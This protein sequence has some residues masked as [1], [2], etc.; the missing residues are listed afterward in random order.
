[1]CIRDSVDILQDI[2]PESMEVLTQRSDVV[3]A[4]HAG[5]P[6]A[7][8]DDP[9]ERGISFNNSE[10]PYDQWQVRWA[11]ALAT[12]IKNVS[13][14]TF[15][16]MLRVSPLGVPPVAAVQKVYHKPLVERLQAM[17]LPDGYAPF[18][19]SFAL[20]MAKIFQEQ[21]V[22]GDLPATDAELIDLFGVGWWK[23]DTE[24]AAKLLEDCL[25]YTSRCV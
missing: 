24:Q 4:W 1:M 18:D 2:T 20:D 10:F 17:T 13:L 16:G 19:S 8:F 7:D 25:L 6:Y 3:R 12:D 21:G 22:G 15:A 14:G 11:L 9:C 23:Y 5:F